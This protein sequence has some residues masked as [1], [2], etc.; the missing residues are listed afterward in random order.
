MEP[1]GCEAAWRAA[2]CS[3]RAPKMRPAQSRSVRHLCAPSKLA[4]A[5]LR[6]YRGLDPHKEAGEHGHAGSLRNHGRRQPSSPATTPL[7]YLPQELVRLHSRRSAFKAPESKLSAARRHRQRQS[8]YRRR[9]LKRTLS[10]SAAA[11]GRGLVSPPPKQCV[12]PWTLTCN[13]AQGLCPL[14][15]QSSEWATAPSLL[16]IKPIKHITLSLSS[17]RYDS[18]AGSHRRLEKTVPGI[19][20]M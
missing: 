4:F 7:H 17:P 18:I 12:S 20:S 8:A 5:G 13:H 1:V 9:T 19:S 15:S 6:I 14:C 3:S 16:L 10:H 11:T 2:W